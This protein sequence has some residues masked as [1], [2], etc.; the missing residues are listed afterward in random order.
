ME[1]NAMRLPAI[2]VRF[3]ESNI[4]EIAFVKTDCIARWLI[5]WL[6]E[7]V[8]CMKELNS[9]TKRHGPVFLFTQ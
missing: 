7:S 3:V 4:S 6:V 9:Q 8:D 2:S 5:L 1:N